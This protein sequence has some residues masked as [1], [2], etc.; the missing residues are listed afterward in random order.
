VSLARALRQLADSVDALP[1]PERE[2]IGR[3]LRRFERDRWI[4]VAAAEAGGCSGLVEVLRRDGWRLELWVKRG[5]PRHASPVMVALYNAVEAS[6]SL[7]TERQLRRI[8]NGHGMSAD[9]G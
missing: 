5:C 2:A 8:I 6:G 7:P 4:R 3:A 1:A 9:L